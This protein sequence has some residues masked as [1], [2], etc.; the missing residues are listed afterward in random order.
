MAARGKSAGGCHDGSPGDENDLLAAALAGGAEVA[1]AARAAKVSART[2]Y[3]R[4][5][6]PAFRRRVGRLRREMVERA[7]A[8]CSRAA[9][10]AAVTLIQA[11]AA[12]LVR[13]RLRAAALILDTAFRGAD[14]DVAERVRELE[15]LLGGGPD[16]GD[17]APA[18]GGTG[19]GGPGPDGDGP[20]DA[21][22]A[23]A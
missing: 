4:L 8:L 18:G 19:G 13:D 16:D 2:A 17:N 12:P 10:G 20:A 22:H 1:E 21:S 9:S 14:L 23:G 15:R 3:R 7:V 6:D 5:R 11:L